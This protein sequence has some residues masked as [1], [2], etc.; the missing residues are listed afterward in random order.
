ML[1]ETSHIVATGG[2]GCASTMCKLILTIGDCT[3]KPKCVLTQTRRFLFGLGTHIHGGRRRTSC[4][5]RIRNGHTVRDLWMGLGPTYRGPA[6]I[7]VSSHSHQRPMPDQYG[8]IRLHSYDCLGSGF[9]AMRANVW[10]WGAYPSQDLVLPVQPPSTTTPSLDHHELRNEARKLLLRAER[11][12][13][14]SGHSWVGGGVPL[15][16]LGLEGARHFVAPNPRS[17]AK[18]GGL[19]P[20]KPTLSQFLPRS[21]EV[22]RSR[23][24]DTS[25]WC[26]NYSGN[27][28]RVTRRKP[29][30]Y[31][32][33]CVCVCVQFRAGR[34]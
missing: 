4:G 5:A 21:T 27:V 11:P 8:Q 6:P 31:L 13:S 18:F 30:E 16:H 20:D 3:R 23:P 17:A 26:E 10:D 7:Q 34:T 24:A 29:Q 19:G 33:M 14:S 28:S 9:A 32:S 2:T 15:R 25:D 22:A 1:R 12:R